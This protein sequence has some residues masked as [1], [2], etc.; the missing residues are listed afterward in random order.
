[1][2]EETAPST[3]IDVST[4]TEPESSTTVD[5]TPETKDVSETTTKTEEYLYAGKYKSAEDLEAG[6]KELYGK[7]TAKT[8][9]APDE[10]KFD[11]TENEALKS[12]EI[13][14]DDDPTYQ[15]MVPLFKELNLS[16]D[17]AN[18]L[19][20]TY[21]ESSMEGITD[22][23]EELKKLGPNAND[24]VTRA[25]AFVAK[26]LSPEEQGIAEQLGQTAEGVQFLEKMAKMRG[27]ADIP[28]DAQAFAPKQTYQELM[29][30][31]VALRK[32]NPN[33][34][35]DRPAQAKYEQMMD[36]AVKLQTG[37]E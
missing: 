26:Y 37:S 12:V 13:N 30:E 4:N 32:G 20:E 19:V 28:V 27:E 18:A 10:Y 31:A 35:I 36:A 25:N 7:F 3:M 29:A 15:K 5:L 23:G 9:E 33:F 16:Q 8:P 1:M 34:D 2:S 17:Q 22:I 24:I 21:L 6:Y 14:L 11:F